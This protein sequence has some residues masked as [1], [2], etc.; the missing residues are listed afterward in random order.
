MG[1]KEGGKEDLQFLG[2][3]EGSLGVPESL[4]ATVRR[5]LRLARKGGP[6][7]PI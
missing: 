5:S 2:E 4:F 7:G 6:L 1:K 3:R